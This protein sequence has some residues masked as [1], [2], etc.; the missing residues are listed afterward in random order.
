MSQHTAPL[1]GGCL[2]G[3]DT[4]TNA[5]A[6]SEERWVSAALVPPQSLVGPTALQ[7]PICFRGP[8]RLKIS[9]P[10]AL[11]I[12][13]LYCLLNILEGTEY[14]GTEYW[15]HARIFPWEK[16]NEGSWAKRIGYG[17]GKLCELW[18]ELRLLT[19]G[20]TATET[21]AGIIFELTNWLL[22]LRYT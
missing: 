3:E 6:E 10:R 13:H 16:E 4:R 7:T 11:C 9:R 18:M 12:P 2:S 5:V 20:D 14:W 8:V 19:S 22:G 17:G 15:K 21:E 1:C